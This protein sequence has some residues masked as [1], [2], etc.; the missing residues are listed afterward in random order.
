LTFTE[1]L[2]VDYAALTE[3]ANKI[4]GNHELQYDLLH[5]SIEELAGK[6]N[7][8]GIIASGGARFYLVR[9]MMIQW[10]SQTGPFHRQFRKQHE[11]LSYNDREEKEEKQLD[12]D[13]VNKILDQLPWYDA[14]LFRVFANGDHNYSTLSKETGIPRTSIA[15][16]IK[17]VRKH[18][19][20]N[21]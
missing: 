9:I 20:A 18:I 19:K 16:T 13:K 15:L 7:L 10:R 4:T 11:E 5:Y 21:L 8:E 6:D 14:E 12:V 17:R 1:Y 2:E 3:A